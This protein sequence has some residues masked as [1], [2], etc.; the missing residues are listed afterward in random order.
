MLGDGE[1]SEVLVI[2]QPVA[3]GCWYSIAAGFDVDSAM[4][5]LS[6]D[7]EVTP[8]NSRL[9][10]VAHESQLVRREV[11]IGAITTPGL[12]LMFAA[13]SVTEGR[14][15]HFNG[16]IERPRLFTGGE[17]SS[18]REA[19]RAAVPASANGG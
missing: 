9:R 7:P 12:P 13:T 14:V 5:W 16:K 1:S 11:R 4:A 10:A 19:V 6:I 15:W 18:A 3:R 8:T 17:P 2:D